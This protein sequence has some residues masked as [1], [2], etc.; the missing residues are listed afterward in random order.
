MHLEGCEAAL[1]LLRQRLELV[2]SGVLQPVSNLLLG[3]KDAQLSLHTHTPR[4]ERIAPAICCI[5]YVYLLQFLHLFQLLENALLLCRNTPLDFILAAR[6]HPH[7]S[8]M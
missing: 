1:L 5:G 3:R 8:D 7:H 2:R 4:R 6:H